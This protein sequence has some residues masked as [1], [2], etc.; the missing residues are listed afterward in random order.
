M[1]CI[2]SLSLG[3]GVAQENPKG[4]FPELKPNQMWVSSIPEK[5][6]CRITPA[7]AGNIVNG[8]TPFLAE[9]DAG[10]Y[11]VTC[12]KKGGERPDAEFVPR[13]NGFRAH[14]TG[15]Q[16]DN[17][18]V[19]FGHI[20]KGEQAGSFIGLVF[21]GDWSLDEMSKLYPVRLPGNRRFAFDEVNLRK[22]LTSR[23]VD[24]RGIEIATDLIG[25]GGKVLLGKESG[26][27]SVMTV[28]LKVDGSFEFVPSRTK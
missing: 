24:E 27:K 1:I 21:G 23:G 20:R 9:L 11:E 8:T 28:E 10:D 5:I 7:G 15:G 25:R 13:F 14:T 16:S 3:K 22:A 17:W 2:S 4:G 6:S 18:F 12:F 19:T 26:A